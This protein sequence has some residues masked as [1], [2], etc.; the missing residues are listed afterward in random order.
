VIAKQINA[1][2]LLG[3]GAALIIVGT[4]AALM[5]P[6][7][8]PDRAIGARI[9]DVKWNHEQHARME[10]IPNCQVCHHTE[11]PG[12]TNPRPCSDC[13][14]IEHDHDLLIAG[15]LFMDIPAKK[16]EGDFGPPP[17]VA[18]HAKCIGCHEA[19]IEGPVLCRDCHQ[20]GS[21]GAHGRAEWD[22]FSHSRKYGIDGGRGASRSDCV[23]CHH[24]DQDA[25]T[26]ADYRPCSACH[27]PAEARGESNATGLKG[28]SGPGEPDRHQGARHGECVTCHTQENPEDDLRT[29]SDCHEPWRF[30]VAAEELP[31]LEQAIHGNCRECHHEGYEGLTARMPL[32]CQDCHERD[33]SWLENEEFGRVF[34]SHER[35]GR[36][37]DMDCVTCHHMDQPGE[38]HLACRSCHG[39][40]HF[41]NPSLK[42]AL[43]QNCTGCHQEKQAGFTEWKQLTI[44]KESVKLFEIEAPEGSFHW[45]HYSHA[46]GDSFSCQEC[47]HSLLRRDG[48]YVTAQRTGLPWPD[49]ATRFRGCG[50][51]HGPDGPKPGSPA[52]GSDAPGKLEAL[53]KVCLECHQRLGCGPQSWEAFFEKPEI[54]WERIKAESLEPTVEA[55]R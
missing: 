13:H 12:T 47:H 33:P 20:P 53:K 8:E 9:G 46:L 38:P 19:M 42:E 27:L 44:K 10:D 32:T 21:A 49:D 31:N 2:A 54:D 48:E 43:T 22:H 1:K 41:D 5:T 16:Y 4:G 55:T 3:V 23:R 6:K 15:D 26:D 29:C 40:G 45:N 28:I 51:C 7:L 18:M 17:M 30:D 24:H 36:Y 37:R 39:T 25:E 14:R 35:H 52:D 11:R 50:A 34:W